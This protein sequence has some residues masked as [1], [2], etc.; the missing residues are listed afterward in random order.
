MKD[1]NKENQ[2]GFNFLENNEKK[3]KVQF[4]GHN[5]LV[6]GIILINKKGQ[7]VLLHNV[8]YDF[9]PYF[10]MNETINDKFNY[11]FCSPIY[12]LKNGNN[13][14]ISI[15]LNK[16]E[17]FE[18]SKENS[19]FVGSFKDTL[20]AVIEAKRIDMAKEI[21]LVMLQKSPYKNITTE[22]CEDIAREAVQLTNK[23]IENVKK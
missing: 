22:L 16:E 14:I 4:F 8:D 13:C 17:S 23:I 9:I 1:F 7:V 5:E 11:C 6:E 18:I 19:G 2:F 3:V 15:E 12:D 21:V 10:E 20:D